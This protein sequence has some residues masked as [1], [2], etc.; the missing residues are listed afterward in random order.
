MIMLA[1][2]KPFNI[3]KA[4]EQLAQERDSINPDQYRGKNGGKTPQYERAK[5]R[6]SQFN[7]DI[8]SVEKMRQ[9]AINSTVTYK[10]FGEGIVTAHQIDDRGIPMVY[11]EFPETGSNWFPP[12]E[13]E[14]VTQF[15]R[16]PHGLHPV[17]GVDEDLLKYNV[18]PCHTL[19]VNE[20]VELC[21][22]R[23]ELQ[24]DHL[25]DIEKHKPSAAA[26]VKEAV[27]AVIQEESDRIK[28]LSTKLSNEPFLKWAGGKSWAVE[29]V[30]ELYAPF[31]NFRLVSLTLGGGAIELGLQPK[32]ALLCDINPYLINCWQWVKENGKFTI[33]LKSREDYFNEIRNRFNAN[34]LHPEAPQWFYLLNH[35]CFN[36]LQR[37][38][39]I[40]HFNVGW[41][42]YKKFHGQSDLTHYKTGMTEWEFKAQSWEQTLLEIQEDDFLVFDPP[43]HGT[44]FKEYYGKFTDDDQMFAAS[45]L[46][47]LSNPMVV[48]NA[49]TPEM[50]E[51]YQDL[52]FDVEVKEVA[53][54]ISCNGDRTPALEMI[55]TKNLKTVLPCSLLSL[56]DRINTVLQRILVIPNLEQ[57]Q[58]EGATDEQ[59]KESL[60]SAFGP[61]TGAS[62]PEWWYASCEKSPKFWLKQVPEGK[63]DLQG[64]AFVE[65]IRRLY[66][67][68]QPVEICASDRVLTNSD[69]V[70]RQFLSMGLPPAQARYLAGQ[71]EPA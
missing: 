42:K 6:Q 46:G 40:K 66:S 56:D 25:S 22:K 30:K 10:Q 45:G 28:M 5:R 8:K 17:D 2:E 64:N 19:P 67:I 71:S 9:L 48:F 61:G 7:D 63:P 69:L 44:G 37:S 4:I 13:V 14:L 60:A 15:W 38:S 43:Y 58:K 12:R 70:Y 1:T 18:I 36:G 20:Q 65:R 57:L 54:S 23:I 32:R 16:N 47:R 62:L 29:L 11:V 21:Q 3:D 55:A 35:T 51:L 26:K 39:S 27:E 41:G 49:A 53:R 24:Q 52:G 31:K 50:L 34:P 68:G 33:P 59:L